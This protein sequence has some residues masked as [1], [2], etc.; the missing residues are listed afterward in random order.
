MSL[1][2]D[3]LSIEVFTSF[4][5]LADC[6]L[7]EIEVRDWVEVIDLIVISVYIGGGWRRGGGWNDLGRRGIKVGFFREIF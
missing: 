5:R 4:L 7:C 3:M 1:I 6:C 2:L